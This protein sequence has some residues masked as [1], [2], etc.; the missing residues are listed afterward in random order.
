MSQTRK[1]TDCPE[2]GVNLV[3]VWCVSG[4]PPVIDALEGLLAGQEDVGERQADVHGT[5]AVGHT[6]GLEL[7][8]LLWVS[9]DHHLQPGQGERGE[10]GEG[11]ERGEGGERRERRE[12]GEGGERGGES[13]EREERRERGEGIGK[14]RVRG[15]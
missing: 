3:C 7:K 4:A 5:P 2:P 11:R 8:H 14:E 15:R 12:R 1:P 10:R 6:V 13:G 9:G